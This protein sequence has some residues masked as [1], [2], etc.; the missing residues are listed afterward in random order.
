MRS[1]STPRRRAKAGFLSRPTDLVYYIVDVV[2]A[3]GV[4]NVMTGPLH[5][6]AETPQFIRDVKAAGLSQYERNHI[7][8]TIAANPTVGDEVRASGGVRKVRFAGR[9]KGKSGGYRAMTAY[10]GLDAPVYLIALLSKGERGNF[11]AAEVANFKTLTA[12]IWRYW[13]RRTR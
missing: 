12:E 2:Y 5:V 4:Y 8:D 1:P 3:N 9:G 6:V 13:R 7:I 10:F 11:T